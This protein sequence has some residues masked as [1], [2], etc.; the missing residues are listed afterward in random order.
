MS[1]SRSHC[2]KSANVHL[3][4]QCNYKCG[5]CIAKGL[6]RKYEDIESWILRLELLRNNGIKKINIAGGEPF[7]YPYLSEFCK[8]CKR[9]GFIVGIT[10]NGS[11]VNYETLYPLKDHIDWIG[12]SVDSPDEDV[13][14]NVGRH[15]DNVLHVKHI[16]DA[17][18]LAHSFGLKVKLNI[19]VIRQSMNSDFS[20]LINDVDPHRVKVFQVLKIENMNGDSFDEYS[21]TDEEFRGF[22]SR[23]ED[24]RLSNGQKLIFEDN[25]TMI[26]SYLALDP[27]GKVMC[28]ENGSRRYLD[29]SIGSINIVNVENYIKRDG[30]FFNK[31]K[32]SKIS[33]KRSETGPIGRCQ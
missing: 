15:C 2:V 10:T 5:F 25:K 8:I 31:D 33:D 23:H 22:E 14:R 9:M 28:D 7:L 32:E 27:N 29:L 6:V 13:E 11:L 3:I 1:D 26:D 4:G 16:I 30:D 18:R 20:K 12:L 19:T 24:I 21:V 17:A